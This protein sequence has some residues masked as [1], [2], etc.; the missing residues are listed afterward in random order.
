MI[1]SKGFLLHFISLFMNFEE[2][3]VLEPVRFFRN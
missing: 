3:S 1:Y 2:F